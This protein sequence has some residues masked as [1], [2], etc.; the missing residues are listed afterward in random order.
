[1][2]SLPSTVITWAL[3]LDEY[4]TWMR[5]VGRSPRT[6]TLRAWQVRKLAADIGGHPNAVTEDDLITWFACYPDWKP[7][8]RHSYRSGVCMF[9]DWAW[10]F[11]RIVGNPAAGLPVMPPGKAV[12][13]PADELAWQ[14]ALRAADLRTTL[15]LRLAGQAGLRRAEIARVHTRDLIEGSG[16]AQ[17]IV[18]GK[19]NKKRLV[20][21]SDGL[22][23]LIRLGAAGHTPGS[24]PDGWLFP[25]G[26]GSHISPL[27]VG[28][29]T[30][31][32]LPAGVT[33]HMLRHMFASKAYRGSRNLRAV[34]QLLGHASIATTERY[35]AVD[36]DEM[37]AAAMAAALH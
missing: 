21:L 8:T 29:L 17:L 9:F 33:L 30:R 2:R 22:A 1:M 35:T 16:G 20:P 13:R 14:E 3:L 18:H 11:G 36:D 26:D 28:E 12:P 10:K 7:E 32:V 6:V 34:Q 27:W 5:A 23:A 19:G 24:S 37:R 15:I 25:N 31:R 4:E